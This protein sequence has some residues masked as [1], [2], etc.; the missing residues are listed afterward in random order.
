MTPMVRD[1]TRADR[2]IHVKA[3]AKLNLSLRIVGVRRDGYHELRTVFQSIA[4]HD[5]LA[6]KSV[7]RGF[8]IRCDD[9]ACPADTT[10]L[11]WR[12]AELLW[13]ASA[14]GGPTPGISV[15][16]AKRIPLEAGLG[17]GSSDAA[18]ALRALTA[19]WRIRV[20]RE[21][22]VRIAAQLGADVPFFLHGGTVLGIERGDVLIPQHDV[23]AAWVVVVVPNFGVSTADAYK[24]FDHRRGGGPALA[25]DL[26]QPV[27]AHHPE[28]A[29]LVHD[30][31][32]DAT[33][34]GMSGSGSAVFGL[35]ARRTAAAQAA[36]RLAGS[37]RRVMLTRTLDRRTYTR[38]ARPR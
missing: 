27:T 3:F 6:F 9:P 13:A 17:G 16:I 11:V 35:F 20:T 10:N 19:L 5:A 34:A 23:P 22:L 31:K 38:L 36:R 29:R 30:L 24:W 21:M 25:N 37:G 1:R 2:T 33:Q 18:A 15:R 4:L 8:R 32:H 7:S 26:E 12:A 28:I 14:R